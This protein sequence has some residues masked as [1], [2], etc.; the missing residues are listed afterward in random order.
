MSVSVAKKMLNHLAK[1]AFNIA[2]HNGLY[3]DYFDAQWYINQYLR[4]VNDNEIHGSSAYAF[5]LQH[6]LRIGWKKRYNPNIYFDTKWYLEKSEAGA[7][8]REPLRHYIE[9]GW[10]EGRSPGPYF[11]SFWYLQQNNDVA[12]SGIEP[13]AH[14]LKHGWRERRNP[15]PFFVSSWYGRQI[16]LADYRDCEPLRHYVEKGWREGL[17]PG[18]EFNPTDYLKR[19]AECREAGV[20]PLKHYLLAG[21]P[22]PGFTPS[23]PLDL[24]GG[25]QRQRPFL[26]RD[27]VDLAPAQ[28]RCFSLSPSPLISVIIPNFNG[29]PHLKDL[30]ES[31]Q[32]QTY[33]NFEVIFVDDCSTDDSVETARAYH[34]DRIVVSHKNVGFA[35]ANNLAMRHCRGELI[36][37]IN[38]DMRVDANWL[39]SMVATMR[40]NPLIAVVASKIRFWTKFQTVRIEGEN[41]FEIDETAL[42]DSLQYRKYFM[43]HGRRQRSRLRSA[44]EQNRSSIVLH[45]PIQQ[46]PVT[47]RLHSTVAQEIKAGVAGKLAAVH[48]AVGLTSYSV[49]ISEADRREGYFIINNAGSA[50]NPNMEPY[51]RGFGDVDD[52]RYDHAEELDLFC[53]GAALIRRDAL[54]RR[55]LFISELFF[56]YEDSELAI[57]LR[58]NGYKIVYCPQAIAYHKHSASTV[59]RSAFWL[60]Q[61]VR[62]KIIFDYVLA[63]RRL[64]PAVLEQGRLHLNHLR[65]TWLDCV[66]STDSERE[67]AGKT[68]LLSEEIDHIAGLI[69]SGD[70]IKQTSPRIGV[71][72]PYWSTFGGGEAHALEVA[73]ALSSFGQVELISTSNFD[74]SALL[75]YF[76]YRD[77]DVRKRV[78]SDFVSDVTKDYDIFVNSCFLNETPSLAK[79][80]YYIVSFPS[81]KPPTKFLDSYYFLSNSEYTRKCMRDFWGDGAF[82]GEVFYPSAPRDFYMEPKEKLEQRK[83]IILSVG[84]F[85][86]TGHIKNQLE[87][88]AAFGRFVAGAGEL[89]KEWKLV[90]VGSVNDTQYLSKVMAASQGLNV[91]IVTEASFETL[92]EFYRQA[93]V[94]V[95]ASGYGRDPKTQPE[96]VEHFGIAVTQALAS[97]CIPLVYD[98]GGPKEIV[99]AAGVG[100]TWRTLDEL[101]DAFREATSLFATP[102]GEAMSAKAIEAAHSYST[103][104]LGAQ[105]NKLVLYGE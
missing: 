62:N 51:D 1:I 34:P 78:I 99:T 6:Y 81:R 22:P 24:E 44:P 75:G 55:K 19:H 64:R 41:E 13:L 80:S 43:P 40:L 95:H 74:L 96:L 84:R 61:T 45:I 54:L 89:A 67:I 60:R 2:N 12:R 4:H 56:Y 105:V 94:Y 27:S 73:A 90:L 100:T 26:R 102:E 15:N 8:D 69:E 76:G 48:L 79:K 17:S 29:A 32:I 5:A 33:K 31:L 98:A 72:N 18:P 38:N 9:K 83:K 3:A 86:S 39:E 88:I 82:R 14:Y 101:V 63:D 10:R 68:D 91:T 49:A 16:S 7:I 25:G 37:L 42:L 28:A 57:W 58:D 59:E 36:A 53:G 20:E 104:R 71:F 11:D 70:A 66:D 87:I 52:G 30:F 103:K 46:E 92:L 97:G 35:E 93:S 85:V 77:L 50:L 21:G 47:L 23:A 65:Q